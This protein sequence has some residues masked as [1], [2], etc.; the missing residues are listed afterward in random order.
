MAAVNHPNILINSYISFR[1][2]GYTVYRIYE[3]LSERCGQFMDVLLTGKSCHE[4]IIFLFFFTVKL[5]QWMNVLFTEKLF[6]CVAPTLNIWDQH[7]QTD[8]QTDWLTMWFMSTLPSTTSSCFRS[9][10]GYRWPTGSSWELWAYTWRCWPPAWW[11]AAQA[12]G[13]LWSLST[14]RDIT[15]RE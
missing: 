6:E 2:F 8:K 7:W 12:T 1:S 3:L 11:L 10:L 9:S 5:I 15:A 14:W 4:L 13:C